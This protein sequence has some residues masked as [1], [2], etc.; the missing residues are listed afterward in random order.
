MHFVKS[1]NALLVRKGIAWQIVCNIHDNHMK[2]EKVLWNNYMENMFC[3]VLNVWH[4]QSLPLNM[5]YSLFCVSEI[6]VM[7]GLCVAQHNKK[8]W[9]VFSSFFNYVRW[10]NLT[11]HWPPNHPW[12]TLVKE[13]PYCCYK[14]KPSY[15]WH[16]QHHLT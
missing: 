16:L 7:Q 12:L 15:C 1:S 9:F 3:V 14:R 2:V 13:I 5:H 4:T 8:M 10:S 6:C 11:H